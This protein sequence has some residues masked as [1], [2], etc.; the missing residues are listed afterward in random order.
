MAGFILSIDV[1]HDLDD[2]SFDVSTVDKSSLDLF[3]F[4]CA[5]NV[6]INVIDYVLQ[7]RFTASHIT[8]TSN[9]ILSPHKVNNF[10]RMYFRHR[11]L[12]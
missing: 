10:Y 1:L 5:R 11:T 12:L 9:P 8:N 4:I 2:F 6:M 7:I 3:A